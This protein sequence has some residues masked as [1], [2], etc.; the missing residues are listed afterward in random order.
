[1]TKKLDLG[2]ALVVTWMLLH[3]FVLKWY[4]H[5]LDLP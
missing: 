1:M 3:R 2:V 4:K 5:Y